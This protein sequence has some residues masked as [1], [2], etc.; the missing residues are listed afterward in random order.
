MHSIFGK[1]N[2]DLLATEE[3]NWVAGTWGRESLALLYI[4]LCLL[5]LESYECNIYI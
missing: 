5:N 2:K 3:E 4:L 1:S